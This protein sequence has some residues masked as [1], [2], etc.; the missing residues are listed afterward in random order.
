MKS[1]WIIIL[2]G[3]IFSNVLIAGNDGDDNKTTKNTDSEEVTSTFNFYAGLGTFGLNKS[4]NT[5]ALCGGVNFEI[6]MFTDNLTLGPEIILSTGTYSDKVNGVF[7]T[8]SGTDIH[9]TANAHYYFDWLF[10]AMPDKYDLFAKASAGLKL[11]QSDYNSH[12]VTVST[13][14]YVGGR[15]NFNN[16]FSFYSFVGVG[17]L[18][19]AAGFSLKF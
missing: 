2:L 7:K 11:Y 18:W 4:Y 16:K 15:Y 12:R 9:I 8:M 6:P 1:I 17:Q 19:A 3:C 10:E 13:G 14:L 5:A